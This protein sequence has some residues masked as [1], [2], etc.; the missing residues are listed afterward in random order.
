MSLSIT[1]GTVAIFPL[2]KY[3][4]S[5]GANCHNISH[6]HITCRL[7]ITCIEQTGKPETSQK[8]EVNAMITSPQTT[9]TYKPETGKSSYLFFCLSQ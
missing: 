2:P 1:D 9:K 8:E 4:I 7:K 5:G 3:A 6:V